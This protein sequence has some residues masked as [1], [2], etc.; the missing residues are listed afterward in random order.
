MKTRFQ[1][2]SIRFRLRQGEVRSL[3]ETGRFEE[4]VAVGDAILVHLLEL[5][6]PSPSLALE[7]S[8]LVAR[9]P[10]VDARRWASDDSVGL[11]YELPEGTRLLVEKDWACLEPAA[12]D[13]NRDTFARPTAV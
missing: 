4:S 8:R 10:A 2:G 3:V 1:R 6:G 12:G 7:G 5:G 11:C 9:I 13:D